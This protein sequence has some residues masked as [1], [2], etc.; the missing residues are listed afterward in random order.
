MRGRRPCLMRLSVMGRV[1]F[2]REVIITVAMSHAA[3]S[4]WPCVV[5]SSAPAVPSPTRDGPAVE[6]SRLPPAPLTCRRPRARATS[7]RTRSVAPPHTPPQCGAGLAHVCEGWPVPLS[8][9]AAHVTYTHS[10][11]L[12]RCPRSHTRTPRRWAAALVHIHA[13]RAAG[14]L[15]SFTYTHSAPLGRCPRTHTHSAPLAREVV[16]LEVHVALEC[17][18]L[19]G[20]A[21]VALALEAIVLLERLA[22]LV[23]V[24]QRVDVRDLHLLTLVDI[25]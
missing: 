5:E 25:A 6:P 14:P 17:R 7:A 12:G 15:P 9:R 2:P 18:F 1:T 23:V 20:G 22:P 21:A 13:L 19:L 4:L 3:T 16:A 11:P 8:A 10:A 24:L